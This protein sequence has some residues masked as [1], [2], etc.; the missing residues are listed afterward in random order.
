M[1]KEKANEK[2]NGEPENNLSFEEQF[3]LLEEYVKK[4]EDPDTTLGESFETYKAGIRLVQSLNG[5]IDRM[6]KEVEVLSQDE[7]E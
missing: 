3:A 7:E 1:A 2:A 6:E 5:M 4:M